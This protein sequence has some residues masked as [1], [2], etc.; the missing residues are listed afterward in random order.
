V[1]RTLLGFLCPLLVLQVDVYSY[2]IIMWELLTREEPY[3]GCP[4]GLQLAYAVAN[5]GLRPPVPAY[6]PAEWARIMTRAWSDNPDDRPTFDDI[7]RELS[8]VQRQFDDML[9]AAQR[10]GG[11]GSSSSADVVVASAADAPLSFSG[12]TASASAAGGPVGAGVAAVLER[13]WVNTVGVVTMPG[14]AAAG[15]PRS[16]T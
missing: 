10:S 12:D 8:V 7:Q 1:T 2:G 14:A 6:C 5:D 9:T 13:P 3:E 15:T 4:A 11:G 16:F